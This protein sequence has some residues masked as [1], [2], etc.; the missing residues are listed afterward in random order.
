MGGVKATLK[1]LGLKSLWGPPGTKLPKK[2]RWKSMVEKAVK[3]WDMRRWDK[4]K[5]LKMISPQWGMAIVS[6]FEGG[7]ARNMDR[8]AGQ[9]LAGVRLMAT[10]ADREEAGGGVGECLI[11]E[12]EVRGGVVHLVTACK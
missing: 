12:E 6:V 5:R 8:K 3:R 2:H 7:K 11:C 1:E 4:W 9:L 10:R